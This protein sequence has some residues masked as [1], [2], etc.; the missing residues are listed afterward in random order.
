MNAL[1]TIAQALASSI[2]ETLDGRE[3]ATWPGMTWA[4]VRTQV[5]PGQFVVVPVDAIA[6]PRDVGATEGSGLPR[7]Q[8]ADWRFPPAPDCT[9]LH[10][11]RFGD[12]WE[13]HVDRVHPKCSAVDHLRHDAPGA[14]IGGG[15]LLGSLAGIATGRTGVGALVGGALALV[16]LPRRG[17]R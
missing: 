8:S 12:L 13:A 15:V 1:T 14:W 4:D 17:R 10:V 5:S 6:H 7:G 3:L 2:G 16:T 11:Q 9:G